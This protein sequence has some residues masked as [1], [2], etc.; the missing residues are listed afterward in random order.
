MYPGRTCD[1]SIFRITTSRKIVPPRAL[2]MRTNT[3][4]P[5]GDPQLSK[6]EIQN[7]AARGIEPTVMTATAWQSLSPHL[8]RPLESVITN[9][10]VWKNRNHRLGTKPSKNSP[11]RSK[12]GTIPEKRLKHMRIGG[13]NF[14]AF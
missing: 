10:A 14:N 3:R 5:P 8:A 9:G 2:S 4:P 7:D 13:A 12:S 1:F 6:H 11:Q